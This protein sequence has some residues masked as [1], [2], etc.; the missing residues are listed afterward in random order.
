ADTDADADADTDTDAETEAGTEAGTEAKGEGR[1]CAAPRYNFSSN[2]AKQNR[3]PLLFQI[4]HNILSSSASSLHPA[5]E[6]TSSP[7][8]TE[9]WKSHLIQP[10]RKESILSTNSV[11]GNPGNSP[12]HAHP[13]PSTPR[14]AHPRPSTP[15]RAA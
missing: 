9:V 14:H 13:H 1:P 5:N 8:M 10:G 12:I 7:S 3:L 11:S 15:I 4:K 2:L 6:F